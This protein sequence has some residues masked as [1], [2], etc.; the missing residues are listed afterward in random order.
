MKIK[1]RVIVE[2]TLV[3]LIVCGAFRYRTLNDQYPNPPVHIV[4][5][6]EQLDIGGYSFE[7]KDWQ[8][9]NGSLAEK[10]MPGYRLMEDVDGNEYP[11]EKERVILATVAITKN[12][13]EDNYLDLTNV[14]YEIGSWGNQTDV[15]LFEAL[16]G[17]GSL[18]LRLGKGETREIIFPITMFDL[19]FKKD[20][21]ENIGQ[22][23]VDIVLAYYPEK[24]VLQVQGE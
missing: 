22:Y 16:N 23:P 2:L 14:A 5:K 7:L 17:A 9:G 1:K 21:W 8:E 4:K 18:Y 15:V 6:G 13:E 19:Q 11:H 12:V 3:I 20:K 24:Y 10:I